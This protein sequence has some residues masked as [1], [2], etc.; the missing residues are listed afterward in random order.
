MQCTLSVGMFVV[1]RQNGQILQKPISAKKFWGENCDFCIK[2]LF[3]YQ[4]RREMNVLTMT[5]FDHSGLISDNI[6]S[7]YRCFAKYLTNNSISL[8]LSHSLNHYLILFYS[9][10]LTHSLTPWSRVQL[11]EL[12]ASL[13]VYKCPALY[14]I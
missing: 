14:G 7:R 5:G 4:F 2:T 8:T 11:E 12:L 10:S 9:P 1:S 13:L 3:K 6:F